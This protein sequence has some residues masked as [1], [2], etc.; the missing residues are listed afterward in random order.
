MTYTKQDLI[1]NHSCTI[2]NFNLAD[3]TGPSLLVPLTGLEILQ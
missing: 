2:F 3:L 1:R